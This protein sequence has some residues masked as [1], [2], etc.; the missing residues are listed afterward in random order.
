[1]KKSDTQEFATRR[2]VSQRRGVISI[3]VG[4]T[5]VGAIILAVV[6]A[7]E[8]RSPE[9]DIRP[10]IRG[11]IPAPNPRRAGPSVVTQY[12]YFP[13]TEGQQDPRFQLSQQMQQQSQRLREAKTDEEKRAARGEL[14]GT[15][16]SYFEE[17]VKA[18]ERELKEIEERLGRLRAQLEKRKTAKREIVDLQLKVIE[19]EAEGLGFFSHPDAA[20]G[21]GWNTG[22]HAYGESVLGGPF[23]SVL[24]APAENRPAAPPIIFTDPNVPVPR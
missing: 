6:R 9:G 10:P 12:Q 24:T 22:R 16:G 8:P 17:D 5:L 15:L 19:N 21:R 11:T 1:M 23:N 14:T 7:Q 18:R 3:L 2:F 13:V 4:A 20:L